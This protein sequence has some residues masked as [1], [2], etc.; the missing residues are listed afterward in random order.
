[1]TITTDFSPRVR[2]EIPGPRSR[3]LQ[4]TRAQNVSAA[5]GT[6]VP[7]YI[8]SASG[9]L[10]TDV[11]GN[12]FIDFG[13]GIGVLTLGHVN[14][15]AVDAAVAQTHKFTHTLFTVT[16]YESYVEVC[17]LL[18]EMTPGTFQ[19]KSVLSSTGA[20]A[21][22][23]AV[24]IARA[25]TGRNGVAVVDHAY[26][27]RT[28]MTL[29]MNYQ[30]APYASGAGPRPGEIYRTN[31]SYPY[32]DGLS[33]PDAARRAIERLEVTAGAENLACL[34]V[35]PIQGEGG[36]IVPADGFL[37]AMQA[38]CNKYGIVVIADEIQVG[39]GR[40]GALFASEHFGFEPDLVVTAKAIAAGFPV[41]AVTGRASIMDA[42]VTGGLSGT[43]SGNPVGCAAAVEILGQ[44]R[45]PGT[46]ERA[47]TVGVRIH[48][49]LTALKDEFPVIGDVRGLGGLHGVELVHDDGRPNPEAFGRMLSLCAERG[50]IALPG[51]DH[52][53][54][55]R[56]LPAITIS[57]D[58][59]DEALHILH[60]AFAAL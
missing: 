29:G 16:P 56:M 37:P 18:N 54:V 30:Y 10:L 1:M 46:M 51:G 6:A 15:A 58:L 48:E 57:D 32:R 27:G 44:L 55:L 13:S 8:A 42:M 20:E 31:N 38:W 59:I 53:H 12:E 28:N 49:G 33:G 35:E 2:T 45:E 47:R 3:E 11:D 41:S 7:V 39:L 40:T 19:K 24:K 43:F 50:L 23:N 52:H 36:I 17:R 34:V 60:E 25:A 21:I 14:A 5:V 26:H 4:K 22:E 9:S